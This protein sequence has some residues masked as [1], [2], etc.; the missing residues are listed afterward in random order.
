[1]ASWE[2]FLEKYRAFGQKPSRESHAQLFAPDATILHPGMTRA[3]SAVEYVDFIAEAL[4]RLPDFHLTPIHW[5]VNGDTIF[6][7]ARNSAIVDGK[8]IEW[9]ATYVI[10]LRDE[11]VIRGRP[12]YDRTE[13]L[14][15][16][17]PVLASNRPKW[18]RSSGG[19]AVSISN[20]TSEAVEVSTCY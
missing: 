11:M 12:Y 20:A 4:K 16:F 3:M 14:M 9:P 5:A 15:P 18:C 1:M 10:T 6:V 2:V 17:E 19:K 8:T 13:A 7:E